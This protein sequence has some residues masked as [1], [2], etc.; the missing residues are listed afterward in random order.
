MS[1][2]ISILMGVKQASDINRIIAVLPKKLPEIYM[3]A[4]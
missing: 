3:N 1:Y 2:E 4:N